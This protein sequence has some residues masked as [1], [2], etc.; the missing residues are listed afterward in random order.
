MGCFYQK[1]QGNKKKA[2]GNHFQT[3]S[4]FDVM[5]EYLR[6]RLKTRS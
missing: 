4:G 1:I 3:A 2:A 6:K 5:N